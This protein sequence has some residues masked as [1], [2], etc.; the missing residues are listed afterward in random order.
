[1]KN[2]DAIERDIGVLRN[3]C[4]EMADE[5][6]KITKGAGGETHERV[7]FR[8]VLRS[9]ELWKRGRVKSCTFLLR[10]DASLPPPSARVH[11]LRFP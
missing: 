7:L 9:V 8:H 3:T 10:L 6:T 1:M 11:A 2:T 4:D 5:V